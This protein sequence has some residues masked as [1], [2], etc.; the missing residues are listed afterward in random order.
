MGLELMMV[1]DIFVAAER[2]GGWIGRV[3]GQIGTITQ[4]PDVAV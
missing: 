4:K 1:I 3:R 2:I